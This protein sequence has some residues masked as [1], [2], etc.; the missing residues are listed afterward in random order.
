MENQSHVSVF[1]WRLFLDVLEVLNP[2]ID[3]GDLLSRPLEL[4]LQE[5]PWSLLARHKN[6]TQRSNLRK[7]EFDYLE[8]Q[9]PELHF[10]YQILK[11]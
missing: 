3:L 6:R 7:L 5:E 4:A 9:I 11:P 2:I 10:G 1:S 8:N